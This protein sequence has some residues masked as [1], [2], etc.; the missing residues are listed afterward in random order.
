MPLFQLLEEKAVWDG[1]VSQGKFEGWSVP[2]SG[3][4]LETRLG[5][6]SAQ[7]SFVWAG[8]QSPARVLFGHS[9]ETATSD[10]KAKA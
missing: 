10:T 9:T 8:Q 4:W 2:R 6:S 5:V 3:D 1:G 7:F